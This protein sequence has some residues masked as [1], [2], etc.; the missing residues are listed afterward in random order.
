ML[1]VI[2]DVHA[3]RFALEAVLADA[4]ARGATA[5]YCLGDVVGYNASP[6]E[7]LRILRESAILTIK[8]NHDMMAYGELSTERCGPNARFS[9]AWTR[10]FLTAEEAG[11]LR[12]LPTEHCIDGEIVLLHS[13]LGDPVSYLSSDADYLAEHG[14]IR[15]WQP[16]ARICF[17]G[18]THVP[19]LIEI[20]PSGQLRRLEGTATTLDPRC[21]Y[22]I[23][24]GSV[25]HP[26][27]SDYRASYALYD[28]AESRVRL[29]RVRYEKERMLRENREHG[30]G[31]DLGRG[32]LEHELYRLGRRLKEA[33]R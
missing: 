10:D 28:R 12:E 23:N 6:R 4:G 8:G 9:Q 17:T 27:G 21:F 13:R 26:R 15:R 2:S 24:P 31:T 29:L 5:T 11:Y 19:R 18:H 25:G 16:A 20:T 30:I 3:N 14:R 22:F 7:T 32:V 33:L 1:A